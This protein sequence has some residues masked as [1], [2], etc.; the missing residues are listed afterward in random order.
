MHDHTGNVSMPSARRST[1]RALR[2]YAAGLVVALLAAGG[3]AV[4]SQTSPRPA[5]C[6]AC[7]RLTTEPGLPRAV[8]LVGCIAGQDPPGCVI[9]DTATP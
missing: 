3:L 2:R 9:V 6:A 4:A 8:C 1:G 5:Q 7:C